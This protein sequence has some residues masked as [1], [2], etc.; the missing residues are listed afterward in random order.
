MAATGYIIWLVIGL[1]QVA[2]VYEGLTSWLGWSGFLAVPACL[3]LGGFPILGNIL[4]MVCAMHVWGW[5]WPLA[6][7][8]FFPYL[9]FSFGAVVV[10]L[11]GRMFRTRR[12]VAGI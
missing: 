12:A 5:G 4:G 10:G 6:A 2:A 8:V 3:M 9:V 11:I 1:V 7:A